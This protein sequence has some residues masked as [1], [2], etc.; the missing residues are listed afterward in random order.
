[1]RLKSNLIRFLVYV[2]KEI[3]NELKWKFNDDFVFIQF[4]G[5]FVSSSLSFDQLW[6][7]SWNCELVRYDLL[8]SQADDDQ[9]IVDQILWF[10]WNWSR[11]INCSLIDLKLMIEVWICVCQLMN[12]R[13]KQKVNICFLECWMIDVLVDFEIK[14]LM[15][16]CKSD[17]WQFGS[18]L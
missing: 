8:Y 2:W 5:D 3:G 7:L 18:F 16:T 6:L 9:V 10:G 13:V 4:G 1:M 12:W 11:T 17:G 14:W 15:I